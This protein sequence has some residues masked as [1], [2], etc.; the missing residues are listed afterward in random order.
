MS[1]PEG[2]AVSL[3]ELV[4]ESVLFGLGGMADRLIG[5]VFLPLTASILA[6]TGFGVYS[7]YSTT[8]QI[9]V[10]LCSVAMQQTFFRFYTE[11]GETER[12]MKVLHVAFTVIH[13]TTLS[14]SRCWCGC[15]RYAA[16]PISWAP[17][18]TVAC[19]PKARSCGSSRSAWAA[20]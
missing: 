14:W 6:S 4:N 15:W 18:P 7:L 10:V 12:Q 3:K 20:R 19:R 2:K 8:S 11:P 9:L 1:K 16:A 5:F 13:V 17:W